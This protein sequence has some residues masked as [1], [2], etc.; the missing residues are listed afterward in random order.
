MQEG[1]EEEEEEEESTSRFARAMYLGCPFQ[2]LAVRLSEIQEDV[3]KR[4]KGTF[5]FLSKQVL[6]IFPLLFLSFRYYKVSGW[7]EYYKPVRCYNRNSLKKFT[8]FQ[9]P[10]FALQFEEEEIYI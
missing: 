7:K 3:E 4:R 8:I 10:V 6:S 5:G 2:R 9:E 1:T